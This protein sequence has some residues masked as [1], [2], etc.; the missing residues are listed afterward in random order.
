MQVLELP[1][2]PVRAARRRIESVPLTATIDHD[3]A[4]WQLTT[5]L[6]HLT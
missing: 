6:H 1:E 4:D 2:P 3:S 5:A